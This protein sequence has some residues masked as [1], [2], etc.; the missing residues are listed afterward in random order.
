MQPTMQWFY[1]N[2]G[3]F[4]L[5]M[6]QSGNSNLIFRKKLTSENEPNFVLGFEYRLTGSELELLFKNAN[7]KHSDS[8]TFW[9]IKV[10]AILK[11]GYTSFWRGQNLRKR[12]L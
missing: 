1:Y 12:A 8:D 4:Y 2:I 6:V 3:A 11:G 9:I 10:D 7:S 5:V